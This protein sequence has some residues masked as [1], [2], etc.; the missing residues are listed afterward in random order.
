MAEK[1]IRPKRQ[2][3]KELEQHISKKFVFQHVRTQEITGF[4]ALD[5][6]KTVAG[7]PSWKAYPKSEDAVKL[8]KKE[9]ALAKKQNAERVAKFKEVE[10]VDQ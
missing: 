5:R 10:V 6:A 9:K 7:S 3:D 2:S 1:F 4:N 8:E